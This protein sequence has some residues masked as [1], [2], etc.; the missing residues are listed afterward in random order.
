MTTTT[1]EWGGLIL[2][3]R[4]EYGSA[5]RKNR[6]R[7]AGSKIHRLHC[8]YVVGVVEGSEHRPGSYGAMFLKSGKPILFHVSPACGC[9]SGSLAGQPFSSLTDDSV[10]CEKCSGLSHVSAC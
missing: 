3:S 7:F 10:T 1:R 6:G 9:T 2:E 4:T 8:E 5:A